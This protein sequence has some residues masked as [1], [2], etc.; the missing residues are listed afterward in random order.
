[1]E[2][3]ERA[4]SKGMACERPPAGFAGSPP[5]S[6]GE[7]LTLPLIEGDKP[8]A[9]RPAG[10]RSRGMFVQ[11]PNEL[12]K[13]NMRRA[14]T[15]LALLSLM[16]VGASGQSPAFDVAD[17]HVSAKTTYAYMTGGAI[18]GGRY[19]I[20]HANMVELISTAYGV[21]AA[22]VLGGPSWLE[23]DRFDVIAKAPQRT[24]PDT[25]KL[26]LQNL[27]ADRF[28]VAVHMDTKPVPAFVLSLGKG[29][30]KLK[31]PEGAGAP[32]CQTLPVPAEPGTIPLNM[33]SCHS[34]TME[35]FAQ[36]LRDYA[37]G[38]VTTIAVDQTGLKG[39]WDFDLKWSSRGTQGQ[40]GGISLFDA[41]D[42]Q[43]GL[44]LESGKAPMPVIV[45]D[46]A[47]QKP[48][49]N[50]SGVATNV[51]APPPAE[52]DVADIKMTP[53]NVQY[54]S[55]FN[56]E[57]SGRL[58]VQSETL[59]LIIRVAWD[60]NS[61]ELVVGGPKWIDSIQ[62][63]IIAKTSAAAPGTPDQFDVD[64]IRLMLQN[65]LIERF[66]L[67][68]HMEERPV[69][70]YTLTAVKPKLQ[71]ADPLGRTG[72]KEGPPPAAKD[73]RDANPVLGRFVTC[74][75]MTMAQLAD[76]LPTM[77]SGYLQTPVL[78]MTG[79]EGAYDFSFSFST[80]GVFRSATQR[81]QQGNGS[82]DAADPSGAI[83]LFEALSKQLGLKLEAQKR[84]LPVLV[85]DHVD[86]K[87]TEN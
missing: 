70:A 42:K 55:D 22:N 46:S 81:R 13:R 52:F 30:P 67:K 9:K 10:G 85:I 26:M 74:T 25:L 45:V 6:G 19:E 16:S 84:P 41:I 15:F 48:T 73:P 82:S 64:A 86:E 77:A 43:L 80:M 40:P 61:D 87:P 60:L 63:N 31:E 32:G 59:R 7:W 49:P 79:I 4:R 14:V 75:N 18:R 11:K 76:L 36:A 62:W 72:W 58:D 33:I 69:T 50:P 71:K 56:L 78:D 20:R 28:K 38:Y 35:R 29:K 65:L 83:S 21:D 51:P 54:G 8:V 44:K 24:S 27:L 68:T 57:P 5:V 17:V 2:L 34:M 37:N 39:G 12:K 23:F 66:H 47:N 3:A 1:M 53:P